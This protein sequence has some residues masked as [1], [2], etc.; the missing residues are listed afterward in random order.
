MASTQVCFQQSSKRCNHVNNGNHLPIKL[1]E[2]TISL[3]SL[4]KWQGPISKSPNASPILAD[5]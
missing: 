5:S 2:L 3:S 1:G 4:R